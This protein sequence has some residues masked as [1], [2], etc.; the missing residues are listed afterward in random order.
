LDIHGRPEGPGQ[1]GRGGHLIG[2]L[3][4]RTN[5]RAAP[6]LATLFIGSHAAAGLTNESKHLL[7]RQ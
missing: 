4:S 2:A 3:I 6:D 5:V 7:L 1:W